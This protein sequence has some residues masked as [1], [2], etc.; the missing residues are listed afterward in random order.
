MSFNRNRQTGKGTSADFAAF[1]RMA[2]ACL[3]P[4]LVLLGYFSA[5]V[6]AQPVRGL[7]GGRL[8]AMP[9]VATPVQEGSQ[10]GVGG[11]ATLKT[12]PDL[13]EV[14]K[15]AKRFLDDEN[16]GVAC[17]MW[18]VVLERSG[19]SLYSADGQIYYSMGR[20]VEQLVRQL[21]PEGLRTYRVTADANAKEILAEGSGEDRRTALS[22]VVKGYFMSSLGDDAAYELGCES[23][24]RFDFVGAMRH[25]K[26]IVEDHP[27]PSV[28][29]D[30]VWLRIGL[31]H[32]YS[33]NQQEAQAALTKAREL[34]DDSSSIVFTSVVSE[35][36]KASEFITQSESNRDWLVNHGNFRRQ[37]VMPSLP[38]AVMES[39]LHP[40][41]QYKIAP[42]KQS[43]RV[44]GDAYLGSAHVG[45]DARGDQ[46]GPLNAV[47]T[48]M[49][50]KWKKRNWRPTGNLLFH[51]DRVIFK[52][53]ADL[54]V[55]PKSGQSNEV[56]W[57]PLW[58]N[59]FVIDDFTRI[60]QQMRQTYNRGTKTSQPDNA[61]EIFF[62]GDSIAQSMSIYR[63]VVYNV[64]GPS[65]DAT[66]RP[67]S[68]PTRGGF[69]YGTIPRRT[70]SNFL[71]AYDLETGYFLWRLPPPEFLQKSAEK[72]PDPD[73][74]EEVDI[75]FVSAPIGYGSFLLVPVNSGG[76]IYVYALDSKNEGKVIWKSY[77]TDEPSGGADPWSPVTLSLE[78]S[79]LYAT[80]GS[81]AFFVL[82]PA[83]GSVRFARRYA[84]HGKP[85]QAMRRVVNQATLLEMDGW[86]EDMVIP[87]GNVAIVFAS[88][89]DM[90]YAYDRQ[91]GQFAWKCP[92]EAQPDTKV[93]YLI[94]VHNHILYAGGSQEVIA[95]DLKGEGRMI[96][97]ASWTARE[98]F[99][100]ATSYGRGMLTA[101]GIYLPIEDSILKLDLE[102]GK[103]LARVGVSLDAKIPVGN[104][105][106][107]GEKIWTVCGNR[108]YALGNIP[109]SAD[110]ESTDDSNDDETT[111]DG[112]SNSGD[113]KSE[114]GESAAEG[115]SK[116]G[117]GR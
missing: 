91:T 98:H 108:F 76:A 86:N 22:R 3:I 61:S 110:E 77:L 46:H 32:A 55:W 37:G 103:P 41:F 72:K 87:Y 39:D 88:D 12:D 75:G 58:L 48:K 112:D 63:G 85:N 111:E 13:E 26:R 59:K 95:Y 99:D 10:D 50:E 21:P 54:T 78:G 83:T 89:M 56:L 16:Y 92:F 93:D 38:A 47:E 66:D 19:D 30:Q 74:P 84:R 15:K 71:T 62:F 90:I 29:L 100:D 94:G 49:V 73:N 53:L 116:E 43:S 2:F 52:S 97:T 107:D 14:L 9:A 82:D 8:I 109:E 80:C 7:R 104:L 57:R 25:L 67:R 24:D 6:Q 106:S 51:E 17:K 31:C 4:A 40:I 105:Y 79:D 96:W 23:L 69:H 44:V 113:E 20:R 18:Q 115:Q 27:D 65:Y 68:D 1:P 117:S 34:S 114:V 81:G 36:K 28:P 35:V 42:V 33:G 64:E 45:D 5:A 70:R 101:D 11:K 60:Q 102:T